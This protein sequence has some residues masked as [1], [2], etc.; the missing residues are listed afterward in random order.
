[1]LLNVSKYATPVEQ[2]KDFRNKIDWMAGETR[3]AFITDIAGQQAVYLQKLEQSKLYVADNNIDP[4][5]V[6]YIYSEA[7]A[8]NVTQLE[9]ATL[10]INL[11][12]FWNNL[13]APQIEAIRI[14][15]K[16]DLA[17][18]TEANVH[19][20]PQLYKTAISML[21]SIIDTYAQ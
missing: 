19:T 21:Q 6:P 20:A 11:A 18:L 10:I 4:A 7:N 17:N 5:L 8:L 16:Q 3:K 12:N 13:L 15:Y 2:I 14:K 1:M 9:A